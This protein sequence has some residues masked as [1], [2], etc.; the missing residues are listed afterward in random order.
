VEIAVLAS[1]RRILKLVR[2]AVLERNDVLD[3]E[4]IDVIHFT[5]SAILARIARP[6]RN[7]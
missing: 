1:E 5:Q 4:G 2:T 6:G 3:M 7:C